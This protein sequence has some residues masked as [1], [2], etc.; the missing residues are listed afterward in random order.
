MLY[1]LFLLYVHIGE[2]LVEAPILSELDLD[3]G[4]SEL[5]VKVAERWA[6]T[7]E[8]SGRGYIDRSIVVIYIEGVVEVGLG[9]EGLISGKAEGGGSY[10][11][12]KKSKKKW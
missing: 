8:R 4:H 11:E 9:V 2:N 3:L 12:E 6:F 10:Q 7:I 1:T 5:N